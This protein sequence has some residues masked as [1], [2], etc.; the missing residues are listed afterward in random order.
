MTDKERVAEAEA[1]IQFLIEELAKSRTCTPEFLNRIAAGINV[2][3]LPLFLFK[4]SRIS[5]TQIYK[6]IPRELVPGRYLEAFDKF[7]VK[8][9]MES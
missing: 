2:R 3:Y 4:K 6:L 1:T 9:V 7:H 5:F 8:R